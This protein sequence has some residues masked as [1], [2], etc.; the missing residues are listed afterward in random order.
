MDTDSIFGR[1]TIGGR[2][3]F[4]KLLCVSDTVV[5]ELD[6]QVRSD[7]LG[8]VDLV[9]SCG[10]LPPEYLGFLRNTLHAPV[11]YVRGNHDIR[12][13]GKPPERCLNIHGRIV[14]HGP[15]KILGLEGSRWYNDGP[16]QY[17]EEQM[18]YMVWRLRPRIWFNGGLNMIVTHAPPRYIHDAEDRCHRGFK[19]F[20]KLIQ[21]Y[22]PHFFLHGHIHALFADDSQRSTQVGDT[23]VVNCYGYCRLE[24][25]EER[26]T[27]KN[28]SRMG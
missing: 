13:D 18:R 19:I 7:K 8:P 12:Y 11:Y 15:L 25:D 10:D 16:I 20:R 17:T 14:R 21:W 3:G 9:I 5:P 26:I 2:I 22:T 6:D 23:R 24:I 27:G 4:M 28:Q 1:L